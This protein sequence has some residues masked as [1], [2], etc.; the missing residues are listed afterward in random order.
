MEATFRCA[1]CS[2]TRQGEGNALPQGW[3]M[4]SAALSRRVESKHYYPPPDG[5]VVA[6]CS[7]AC[8]DAM[9]QEWKDSYG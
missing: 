9:L 3:V 8:N 5:T 4:P 1:V 2:T 7:K 6:I